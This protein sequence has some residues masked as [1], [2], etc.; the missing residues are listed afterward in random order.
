MSC[1][2]D[3]GSPL[4]VQNQ[5]IK[6]VRMGGHATLSIHYA[7]CRVVSKAESPG[8]GTLYRSDNRQHGDQ[9]PV[10]TSGYIRPSEDGG[11]ATIPGSATQDITSSNLRREYL[12]AIW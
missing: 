4:P 6:E 3:L 8:S 9:M 5:S 1:A 2:L 7:D 12:S 11:E 10:A